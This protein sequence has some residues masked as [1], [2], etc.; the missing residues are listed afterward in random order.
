MKNPVKTIII[1][2]ILPKPNANENISLL[3]LV[4]KLKAKNI[5]IIGKI[6]GDNIEIIP[7][8]NEI[9]GSISI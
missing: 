1:K 7:V 8:K 2:N 6:H 5:G 3:D 9:K 4:F